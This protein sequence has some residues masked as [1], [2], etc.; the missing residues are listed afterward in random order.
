M[1][2]PSVRQKI[3]V[4]LVLAVAALPLVGC[5]SA[6]VTAMYLFK[7]NV[8]DPEFAGLKGKKV[9]VVCRPMVA[10]QYRNSSVARDLA[11][12]ITTLLEQNVPKIH[13]VDQRK[14]NKW[15]DENTWE[16]YREV[17]KALKADM[18]VGIDLESFSIYQGQTLYQG[19]A[20]AFVAVYDCEK[21]GKKVFEKTLPQS[22]YPPN[23]SVPTSEWLEG[24]FRRKFVGVLADQIARH[25]YEHDPYPDMAQ[26]SDALK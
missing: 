8:V 5:Q 4:A 9:A 6:L 14:V 25:F 3:A 12:Q 24:D 1:D 20:N 26:D 13:V 23:S 7:G 19:K 10:L 17:G 22:V 11:Q 15:I 21:N 2:R 16:E 18:V